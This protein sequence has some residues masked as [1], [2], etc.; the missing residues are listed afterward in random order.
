VVQRES[1]SG[2]PELDLSK[3]NANKVKPMLRIN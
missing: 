2:E 3:P 1:E